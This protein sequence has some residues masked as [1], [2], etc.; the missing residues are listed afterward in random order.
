[1][2]AIQRYLENRYLELAQHR[3]DCYETDPVNI[4]ILSRMDGVRI[5]GADYLDP[6]N[7]AVGNKY[8]V[9]IANP[10]FARNRDIDHIRM[11]YDDLAEGGRLVSCASA[12]W[13]YA[14]NK[15]E[16]EFCTWL[17][18]ELEADVME[19]PAGTFKASGT[20]VEARI[21]LIDK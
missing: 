12:H 1:V 16:K 14:K 17:Y 19:I 3:V 20:M 10:P 13:E 5:I 6:L 2:K 9:I 21:I 11:M 7:H 4:G 8:D 15:K 18:D